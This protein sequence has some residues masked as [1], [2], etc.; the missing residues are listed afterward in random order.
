MKK[1]F[2]TLLLLLF[3]LLWFMPLWAS[4]FIAIAILFNLFLIKLIGLIKHRFLKK[5]AKSIFLFIYIFSIAISIKLF[6]FDIYKIPSS[7]MNNTLYTND[8]IM[9][10]KLELGPKLPRSP[11]DIPWIN[12]A[13]YFNDA[14]KERIN[15]NWWPY[16]RLSGRTTIKN[17]DVVVFTMFKKNMVIVKRCMGIAGDTLKIDKGNVY[18]NNKHFS[19]SNLIL[20]NYEFNVKDKKTLYRKLDSIGFDIS[21]KRTRTGHFMATLSTQVKDKLKALY[22]VKDLKKITDSLVE[23]STVY[24]NSKYNQWNLDDYGPYIIPKKGL[25]IEL[26]PMNFELYNKVIDT[27]EGIRIKDIEGAYFINEKRA[28]T[29][30]FKQDYFFMMGDNRKGSIDSRVWGLVPEK[31]IIGKVQYILFSNYQDKFQWNRLF[32]YVK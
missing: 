27:H 14:A 24:P 7:S 6:F 29:Y 2:I 26:N 32:K 4:I 8:V 22:L 1:R 25:K 3:I 31:R 18:I 17:G 16:K 23:T 13:F 11:F 12:I 21:M 15:E 10:N 19:P 30:T 5:T 20:N 28:K 9:V